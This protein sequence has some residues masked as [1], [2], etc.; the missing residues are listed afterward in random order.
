MEYVVCGLNMSSTVC[1]TTTLECEVTTDTVCESEGHLPCPCIFES[2]TLY[3]SALS[4]ACQ[5]T[6]TEVGSISLTT[7]PLGVPE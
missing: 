7:I 3:L 6:L 1:P 2:V 5:D 4:A